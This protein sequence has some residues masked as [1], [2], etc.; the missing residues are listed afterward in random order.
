VRTFLSKILTNFCL[1]KGNRGWA[2]IPG[3]DD[4]QPLFLF[5]RL[6]LD[7]AKIFSEA[8]GYL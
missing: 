1:A 2:K 6:P 8:D 3:R 5:T 4:T 7:L